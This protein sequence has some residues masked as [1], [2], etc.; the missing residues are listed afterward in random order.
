MRKMLSTT[1][2][3]TWW[4]MSANLQTLVTT[5]CH[6]P[7]GVRKMSWHHLHYVRPPTASDT[8]R[9]HTLTSP[10]GEKSTY[11]QRTHTVLSELRMSFE[12]LY[13]E[14][15]E[16]VP[17]RRRNFFFFWSTE[18]AD[19]AWHPLHRCNTHADVLGPAVSMWLPWTLHEYRTDLCEISPIILTVQS[20]ITV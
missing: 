11:A 19:A 20:A 1:L 7:H 13:N 14:R 4:P 18:S 12:H 16:S 9:Q 5:K 3:R 10:S 15:T 2:N 17:I 6:N 8:R